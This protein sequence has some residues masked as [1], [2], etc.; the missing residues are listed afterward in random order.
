MSLPL[1]ELLRKSSEAA[2]RVNCH[3]VHGTCASDA[4]LDDLARSQRICLDAMHARLRQKASILDL[5]SAFISRSPL[6][7][8]ISDFS[9]VDD[10]MSYAV[11]CCKECCSAVQMRQ[12]VP[13]LRCF[14]SDAPNNSVLL[15]LFIKMGGLVAVLDWAKSTL[16]QLKMHPDSQTMVMLIGILHIVSKFN[17][18][19]KQTVP[20]GA[21]N[22]LLDIMD[23]RL[24]PISA[25]VA[26]VL[27]CWMK[28][29]E[30]H[31]SSST[32][33]R[34]VDAVKRKFASPAAVSAS[35]RPVTESC[36]SVANAGVPCLAHSADSGAIHPLESSICSKMVAKLCDNGV[37]VEDVVHQSQRPCNVWSLPT[38]NV[39]T[40]ASTAC[41]DSLSPSKY[42][43]ALS[44]P[45]VRQ[46]YP[47][48]RSSDALIA[49]FDL[50]R[51]PGSSQTPASFLAPR[52][53]GF[54]PPAFLASEAVHALDTLASILQHD[55]SSVS[56]RGARYPDLIQTQA[57]RSDIAASA[58]DHSFSEL[59]APPAIQDG[60]FF[61]SDDQFLADDEIMS[62][63]AINC[64]FILALREFSQRE[65]L[66]GLQS[67]C[68]RFRR[69]Q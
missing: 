69:Q 9:D 66:S 64:A 34:S 55:A 35:F 29:A 40:S 15:P 28:C 60:D 11:K 22:L 3:L 14:Q 50:D 10:C 36:R 49:F 62:S 31:A 58:I 56:T 16:V 43:P 52:H 23:Q 18:L 51:S 17:V 38:S 42:S 6:S 65:E 26:V 24:P 46:S 59:F 63:D 37:K 67:L 8:F 45:N 30:R 25:C 4:L 13:L 21:C 41:D 53:S 68:D 44:S 2:A 1:F 54:P 57:L 19:P 12:L 48:E 32:R 33:K 61:Y 20:S 5:T 47:I 27:R 7:V 39:K